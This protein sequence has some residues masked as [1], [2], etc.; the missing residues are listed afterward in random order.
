MRID[1]KALA[2]AVGLL[3]GGAI[4]TLGLV[5]MVRPGYGMVV[6]EL[7]SSI[8][9]GF[10]IF[11]LPGL[12]LALV[13]WDRRLLKTAYPFGPFMIVGALLGVLWGADLWARFMAA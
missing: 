2:I 1:A 5:S 12:V 7:A 8:Y 10:L 11:G 4:L 3:W 9:A 6:L 13:R